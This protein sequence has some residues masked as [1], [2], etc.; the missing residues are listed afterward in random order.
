MNFIK[1]IVAAGVVAV[2]TLPALAVDISGAGATF[3][4]P[5]YAKWADA[6][7]KETGN[8]LNYQSIGSGGG[9]KQIQAKTVTFGATDMPLKGEE[10]EKHGL[11]QFPTVM[12]GVVPV[13]NLDGVAAG[14]LVLDGVTLAKI[15]Q[16][17]V[18]TWD[19]AA[20]KKLNPS[21]KLPSQAIVVVH[22]SD[23]SGTTFVFTDYLSKVSP[24][25]KSKVGANTAVEWPTG[26]GAKG[27]EG[28]ANNVAQTKGSIGY[29]EYA[30]AKQ[31]KLTFTKL[32]NTA[33]KTVAPTVEAFTAAA[34]N[35]NWEGTPGFGVILTNEPGDASW[36]ISS[37]TFILIH[38]QPQDAAA[39]T[40]A[41]KFFAW[42]YAKGGAA[43]QELDYVP[44]PANVIKS[45]QKVWANDIKDGSG[46]ALFSASN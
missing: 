18:K 1:A 12:G 3:P 15:F 2:S 42:A 6:Y 39:A 28:V 30:Y 10:L 44:M 5:I 41:L 13:V 38:K 35:A 25:W 43:A 23:G 40:E 7:K 27:N 46:K 34:A 24:D 31:N 32:I 22:R 16:G 37:A 19:D 9:I 33:G 21:A 45:I 20:I 26:L 17:E 29:V 4:Y 36:P 14:E 8:G 11:V